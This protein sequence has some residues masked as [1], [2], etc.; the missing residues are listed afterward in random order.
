MKVKKVLAWIMAAGVLM[1]T[2]PGNISTVKAAETVQETAETDIQL[3][4]NTDLS[5][6]E[7]LSYLSE[8]LILNGNNGLDQVC[9]RLN[10]PAKI[11][12]DGLEQVQLGKDR[13][14][15]KKDAVA[16]PIEAD[17]TP[18]RFGMVHF[19]ALDP[20]HGLFVFLW[21][22][23]DGRLVAASPVTDTPYI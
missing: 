10:L 9:S 20:I 21:D 2:L 13:K 1:S 12:E 6:E 17:G 16:Y 7:A 3:E 4:D 22:F 8:E 5:M 18:F 19:Q 15:G 14:P 11:G 23:R